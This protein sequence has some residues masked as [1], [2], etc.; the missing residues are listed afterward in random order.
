VSPGR[1]ALALA[2][3]TVA[4]ARP[5]GPAVGASFVLTE[6]QRR[7]AIAFGQRSI[8]RDTLGTEWQVENAAGETVTVI[9][10][11]HR[12]AL[13][14]RHAAFRDEPLRP[15]DEQRALREVGGRLVLWVTLVGPREDFARHLV[16]RLLV[17]GREIAPTLAQNER[18]ALPQE[19]GRFLARCTYWFPSQGIGGQASVALVV[20]DADGRTV[21]R[22]TIDLGRM[23]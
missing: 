2:L 1:A 7:E 8:T 12:L 13:A 22:F 16:P 23:R 3:A 20:R 14:A 21:S 17:A 9:T 10:P 18:T 19:D 4:L 6:E 5:A 11:F 15:E